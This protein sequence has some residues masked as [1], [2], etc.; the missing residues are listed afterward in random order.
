MDTTSYSHPLKRI[1][2]QKKI[3]GKSENGLRLSWKLVL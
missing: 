2:Q 1:F 3:Q